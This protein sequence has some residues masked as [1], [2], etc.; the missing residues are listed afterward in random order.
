MRQET[1]FDIEVEQL[2]VKVASQNPWQVP[3]ILLKI[4]SLAIFCCYEHV[5]V[6]A[7]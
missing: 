1:G 5:H 7:K 6:S 2:K 3:F 4:Y